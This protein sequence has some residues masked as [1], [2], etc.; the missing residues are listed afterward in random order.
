MEGI[1]A[2]YVSKEELFRR[3]DIITFHCPLTDDTRHMVNAET[4]GMMKDGS[5]IVNTSRG[6]I[7]DTTALV[8][9]LKAGKFAGV[10]LD[11]YEEEDEYFF[12]DRSNEI[13]SDDELSRLLT[14]PNV[15]VTSHQAFFTTEAM[16]A[17]AETTLNNYESAVKGELIQGNT[18][19]K[20]AR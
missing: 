4:I 14:F 18:L 11:V 10:A 3:S 2:K 15:L 5:I 17:I 16:K 20:R 6:A 1:K 7:V 9:A 13:I 8:E 12:E 19:A